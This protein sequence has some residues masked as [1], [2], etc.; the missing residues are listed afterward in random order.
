MIPRVYHEHWRFL[1]CRPL[2]SQSACLEEILSVPGNPIWK[3]ADPGEI[4]TWVYR[5]V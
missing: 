5:P 3:G 2:A 1:K 4:V